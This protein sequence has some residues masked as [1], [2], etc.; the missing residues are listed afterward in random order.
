MRKSTKESIFIPIQLILAHYGLPSIY[1]LLNNPPAQEAWKCT[2]KHKIHEVVEASWKSDIENKSCTK[3]L[4]ANVL[5]VGSSHHIWS[6][7]L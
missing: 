3:Y 4:N 2:I 7:P 1:E 6:S 5:N